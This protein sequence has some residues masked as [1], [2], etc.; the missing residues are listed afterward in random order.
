M[1][2]Y[3]APGP[4]DAARD[5][6]PVHDHAWRLVQVDYADGRSVREY[7]CGDCGAVWFS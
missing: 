6:G 4:A 5:P 2:V 1:T 7:A 3:A